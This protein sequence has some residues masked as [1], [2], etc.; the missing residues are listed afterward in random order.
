MKKLA[1]ELGLEKQ[2]V[3]PMVIGGGLTAYGLGR[4]ATDG[5]SEQD[6]GGKFTEGVRKGR[7]QVATLAGLGALIPSALGHSAKTSLL[8]GALGGGIGV[9]NMY[10]NRD[11]G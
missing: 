6:A 1:Y 11:R 4:S 10:K 3:L 5:L 7:G 9:Y 8:G 2:A